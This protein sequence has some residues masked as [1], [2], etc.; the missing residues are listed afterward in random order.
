MSERREPVRRKALPR[1]RDSQDRT[2]AF[3][4]LKNVAVV[5]AQQIMTAAASSAMLG[6]F[7]SQSGT[8]ILTV[9]VRSC[10]NR[11]RKAAVVIIIHCVKLYSIDEANNAGYTGAVFC[12][13]NNPQ[14]NIM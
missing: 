11:V 1:T 7:V 4:A 12:Q 5:G 8:E 9:Y 2:G 14:I 10:P 13:I 3:A 6:R